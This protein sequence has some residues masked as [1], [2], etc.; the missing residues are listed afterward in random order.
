[1]QIF[2]AVA[3]LLISVMTNTTKDPYPCLP[4]EVDRKWTV[5]NDANQTKALTVEQKLAKLKAKCKKGKLVD[6]HGKE[7]RFVQLIGCWGNP[8]ADYQEQIEH[9]QKE[10]RDLSE[11]YT[12]VQ[13]PCLQQDPTRIH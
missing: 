1:M 8:P 2:L 10:V 6:E 9:Q 12:V 4:K 5:L 7:I 11:K 13:I 3:V